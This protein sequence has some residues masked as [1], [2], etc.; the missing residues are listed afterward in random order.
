MAS[1]KYNLTSCLWGILTSLV[2]QLYQENV[3]HTCPILLWCK[4]GEH[5]EL[6]CCHSLAGFCINLFG[7]ESTVKPVISQ[8][9]TLLCVCAL[10]SKDLHMPVEW[11]CIWT[12]FRLASRRLIIPLIVLAVHHIWLGRVAV[13][14][15]S[16]MILLPLFS[17]TPSLEKDE[18]VLAFLIGAITHYSWDS[19]WLFWAESS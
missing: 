17:S 2:S 15:L 10:S 18:E 4:P 12:T 13:R 19:E 6:P 9:I 5:L 8:G 1:V 11:S 3:N 16:P 14:M 7:E